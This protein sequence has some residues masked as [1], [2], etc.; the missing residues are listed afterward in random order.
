MAAGG[1]AVVPSW[2][3]RLGLLTDTARGTG[4]PLLQDTYNCNYDN[5]SAMAAAARPSQ[6][7]TLLMQ[8]HPHHRPTAPPPHHPTD[9]ARWPR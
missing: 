7:R 4:A 1:A 6:K 2:S 8:H 5:D 9:P 3:V